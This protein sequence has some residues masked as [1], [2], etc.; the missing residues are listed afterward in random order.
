L[1]VLKE[2]RAPVAAPP[3]RTIDCGVLARPARLAVFA[4]GQGTNFEAL[5]AAEARGALGGTIVALLCDR[6]GAPVL[7]RA[8]R[9]GVE[10]VLPPVGRFRSR[11]DDERPW[12]D[13]LRERRVD[14]VLLAGFMRRLHATLLEPFAGR[15]LNVHPSLLPAFPGL[16]AIG[17]AYRHGVRVTGV[18]IHLVEDQLD[19]GPILAQSAFEVRPED[20]VESLEERVH[21][22]EY[23]LYPWTVRR[24]L[25]EA[26]TVNGR[27]FAWGRGSGL[28]LAEEEATRDG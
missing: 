20:T 23:T 13:A 1:R 3:P 17:R 24:F 2:V 7:D 27:Q 22:C 10:A 18:T 12:L 6:P 16:D 11:L 19:E 9:R 21:E 8:R 15:M 14:V 25:T 26:W 4:S 5:A 28:R